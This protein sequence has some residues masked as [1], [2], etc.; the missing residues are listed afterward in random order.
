MLVFLPRDAAESF[1]LRPSHSLPRR[2][3]LVLEVF[4]LPGDSI[5][6]WILI[7]FNNLYEENKPL[8][9]QAKGVVSRL[10]ALRLAG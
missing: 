7:Y 5:E 8:S 4:F 1:P 2:F 10:D 6:S 9:R 3:S